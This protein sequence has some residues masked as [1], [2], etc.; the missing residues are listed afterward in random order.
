MHDTRW[1]PVAAWSGRLVLP[2]RRREDG[3]VLLALSS[4]PE[5][6]VPAVGDT[7]PLVL[8]PGSA[9][10]RDGEPSAGGSHVSPL[11]SL[12]GA[13]QAYDVF[14]ALPGARW[15]GSALVTDAE[16]VQVPGCEHA[17]V[18]IACIDGD[19]CRLKHWN[20]ATG[21]FD[22]PGEDLAM[23]RSMV[24]TGS[25]DRLSVSSDDDDGWY[26]F[27]E[28]G[29]DGAWRL[30]AFESR[31]SVRLDAAP[32]PGVRPWVE[33][34]RALAFIA[35][36]G[37]PD[38]ATQGTAQRAALGQARAV[39]CPFTG[40]LVLEVTYRP[41]YDGG[42]G[43]FVA[44]AQCRAAY[45]HTAAW[46]ESGIGPVSETFARTD[47]LDTYRF[48]DIEYDPLDSIGLGLSRM[49]ASVRSG[50]AP[51]DAH[52]DAGLS[53]R[54]AAMA[55]RAVL[56]TDL[57]RFAADRGFTAALD[58]DR[59]SPGWTRFARLN[60]L[61]RGILRFLL[62]RGIAPRRW[63]AWLERR[64]FS[65]ILPDAVGRRLDDFLAPIS[66]KPRAFI[67]GLVDL[68]AAH[69]ASLTVLSGARDAIKRLNGSSV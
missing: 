28:P 4:R 43:G 24:G 29:P 56:E 17:L 32:G 42:P 44:G 26:A 5:D 55:L 57:N 12:A 49:A 62:P 36:G 3:G 14:V 52:E 16:P 39:R 6:G 13:R 46:E 69:G 10:A 50:A 64:S 27:R 25:L 47:L 2:A 40:G 58:A 63:D 68:F 45:L 20:V 21:G 30:T 65:R 19:H 37:P 18:H 33:G 54:R 53:S 67:G 7:V 11:E 41:V 59:G 60:G 66:G 23:A 51:G 8:D 9:L 61:Y 34:D 48:G 15:N 38:R 31:A 1:K 35:S 22:G